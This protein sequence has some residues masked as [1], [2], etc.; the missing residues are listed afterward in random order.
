MHTLRKL[1]T[2]RP[3]MANRNIRSIST[4]VYCGCILELSQYLEE[5]RIAPILDRLPAQEGIGLII[6]DVP[7][8]ER[9]ACTRVGD[10]DYIPA[11]P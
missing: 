2:A 3:S 4:G 11:C 6:N 10:C 1:P 8:V 9:L 7:N 5:N